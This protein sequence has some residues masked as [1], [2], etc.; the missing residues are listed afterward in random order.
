MDSLCTDLIGFFALLGILIG[1]IVGFIVGCSL[2][3]HVYQ[4]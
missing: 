1:F 3:Q 4:R 2:M